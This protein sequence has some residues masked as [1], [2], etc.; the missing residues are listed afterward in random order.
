MEN[1]PKIHLYQ[2][3]IPGSIIIAGILIALAIILTSPSGDTKQANLPSAQQEP[4]ANTEAVRPVS[5]TDHI[6][7]SMDAPFVIVGYSD[8]EC[9]FCKRLHD[10]LNE[11]VAT[12]NGE[13]AWVFRQFPLEQLHPIKAMAVAVASECVADIGGPDAFWQFTDGYFA[14]T[15]GNNRTDINTVIPRLV[16]ETGINQSEFDKCVAEN[17]PAKKI[18]ADLANAI[19]TGG[20]GTPWSILIAPN[21]KTYPINGALPK[22]QIMS[23]IELARGR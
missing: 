16:S 9:P 13:V 6:K 15:L 20:I 7:G 23:L 3:M 12:S 18:N 22:E 5:K 17:R 14:V 4:Q 1:P 21:G 8:F 19:E 10:S 11:I 2:F